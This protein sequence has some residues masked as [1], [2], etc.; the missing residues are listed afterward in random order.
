MM[1][2]AVIR[3]AGKQYVVSEGEKILVD[4][5]DDK[6]NVEVLAIVDGD[7]TKVGKPTVEGAKVTW[8]VVEEEVKGE[9]LRVIRYKSKKRVHKEIG[10]RQKYTQILIE[11]IA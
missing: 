3:V 9:K 4:L 6:A 7:A 5:L 2:K 1:K 11:K 8:K 10:H